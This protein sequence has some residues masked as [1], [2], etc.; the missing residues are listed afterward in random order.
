MVPL[1]KTEKLESFGVA[2]LE[3]LETWENN[4][5]CENVKKCGKCKNM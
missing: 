3:K 2:P 4:D 1:D 5:K